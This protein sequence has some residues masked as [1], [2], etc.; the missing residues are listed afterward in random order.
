MNF[1]KG[2]ADS[3]MKK[4]ED[5]FYA[6]VNMVISEKIT[7]IYNTFIIIFAAVF[8]YFVIT[9][10]N[11]CYARDQSAWGVEYANTEDVTR[12]FHLLDAAG[13]VLLLVSAL[14]YHLQGK[15]SMFEMMR[16][17]VIL[18]NI[19]TF[20]WFVALQYYRFK[21]TGRACSGDFLNDA[22][23]PANFGTVY[24]SSVG[25]WHVIYIGMQYVL[26]IACKIVAIVVT[27]KLETELDEAKAKL[28][29]GGLF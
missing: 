23:M 25:Q 19:C 27:N 16:P 12:Q 2:G 29:G 6:K 24:L 9:E 7:P 8:A 21:D 28:G 10:D 5:E 14:M 3:A 11:Q 22:K 18:A 20:A 15:E 13:L 26:Y 17:Y 4:L 1:I